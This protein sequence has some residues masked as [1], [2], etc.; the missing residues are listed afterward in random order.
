MTK[1][2]ALTDKLFDEA[3]QTRGN[4]YAPYSKFKV[5]A[6]LIDSAG[7]V[8][9]GCNFENSSYGATICAE[10]NAIGAMIAAGEKK[11]A[12]IVIVTD[13]KQGCPPC[14]LCLQVLAEFA[15]DPRSTKVHIADTKKIIKTFSLG[16]LLPEAFDSRF[17]IDQ[18]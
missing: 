15:Q 10:R 6:A 2:S 1:Q 7:G 16:E 8:H 5:G 9:V 11:F 14:G 4:A 17:L 3:V 12:E 18:T 13:S